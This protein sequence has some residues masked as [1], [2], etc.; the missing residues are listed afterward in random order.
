MPQPRNLG[1]RILLCRGA[2]RL[3]PLGAVLAFLL[4]DPIA[5]APTPHIDLTPES[6]APLRP[7]PVPETPESPPPGGFVWRE[8]VGPDRACGGT[9][10]CTWERIFG[11]T[12]DDK[13]SAATRAPSGDIYVTGATRRGQVGRED[14]WVMRLTGDGALRWRRHFGTPETEEFRD[15]V[16]APGGGVYVVGHSRAIGAGESDLWLMRLSGSGETLFELSLGGPQNDRVEAMVPVPD[17]GVVIAGF[18]ASE[19]AGGR[20][21]W[22]LRILPEGEVLWSR[23]FGGAGHDEAF[24]LVALGNGGFALTGHV[25]GGA[26]AAY[27]LAVL[28][29]DAAGETIWQRTLDRA[30]FEAGTALAALDDGGLVV[31]GTTSVAGLRDTDLW[32]LRL[33]AEGTV[34]WQRRFGGARGEQ[35]SAVVA[36]SAGGIVVAAETFSM[37][38]GGGDIWLLGL[39]GAGEIRW[40][41]LFGGVL[42]D[43]PSA[44]IGLPDGGLLLGGHTASRGSGLEDG[45]LL[46]LTE[47]GQL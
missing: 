28:R 14:A 4:A 16:P 18:T 27:D 19:G 39:T 23:T 33:D 47:D 20:D 36:A 13:L 26:A 24:D 37:G 1:G 25:W 32:V 15:I 46:R 12:S 11:G 21:I 38:A 7:G 31:V 22:L 30:R 17:G 44:L 10:P 6:L 34:R 5:A 40:E 2:V 43:H 35:P 45:W 42:W 9:P 29:V 8:E 3:A 41:Q